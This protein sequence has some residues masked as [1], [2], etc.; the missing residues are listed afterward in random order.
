MARI[1]TFPKLPL[2]NKPA[3]D[4]FASLFSQL[5]KTG[6]AELDGS[7]RIATRHEK[8]DLNYLAMV[9]LGMILL[10]L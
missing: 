7:L 6:I 3:I 8:R 9:M 1:I 4:L 2:P 10:L 5:A